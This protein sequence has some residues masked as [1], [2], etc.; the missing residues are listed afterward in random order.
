VVGEVLL[1]AHV[2][3]RSVAMFRALRES[4]FALLRAVPRQQWQTAYGVHD[5]RGRQTIAE[6]VQME[7]G[8]DLNHLLQIEPL[9]GRKARR[10]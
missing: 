9:L 3:R 2:T 4:N 5:K 7:A 8:H 6:F 1:Q 10:G